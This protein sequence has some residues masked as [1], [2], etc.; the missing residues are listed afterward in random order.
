L[1]ATSA[2]AARWGAGVL[3]LAAARP[4]RAEPAIEEAAV[5]P[6]VELSVVGD[7]PNA[8]ALVARV[9]SWFE[10]Q[11]TPTR[12]A[13][14][15][16]VDSRTVLAAD[17]APGLRVWIVLRTPTECRVFFT[18]QERP[19]AAPRYLVSDVALDH[20][21]D[22]LGM[23]QVAQV[24]FLSGTALWAGTVESSPDEVKEGLLSAPAPRTAERA[25]PS[26]PRA[27]R[28]VRRESRPRP[29]FRAGAEYGVRVRGPEGIQQGPS[30]AFSV[31]WPWHGFALGPIARAGLALPDRLERAGASLEVHGASF[32][33]GAEALHELSAH[34]AL[35]AALGPGLDV[36]R[37]DPASAHDPSL[38]PAAAR[39]DLRPFIGAAIG[40]RA[41]LGGVAIGAGAFVAV[42]TLRTHYDVLDGRARS[43]V[44]VPWVVQ[45]GARVALVF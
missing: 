16:A 32:E 45:P 12:T 41:E 1:N 8:D 2:R 5:L 31:S 9:G 20:G 19:R 14:L 43:E 15:L 7:D 13:H 44:V 29:S 28:G 17:D 35:T 39:L 30:A 23:E 24:V 33:L 4:G 38:R 34:A 25:A 26:G 10:G 11:H 27:P 21:L 37:F 6:R 36:V 40:V 18:V 22:E 42:Q 3:L